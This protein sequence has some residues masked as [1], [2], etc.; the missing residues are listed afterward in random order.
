VAFVVDEYGEILGSITVDDI[1]EEI[2]GEFTIGI[3][4][5]EKMIHVQSD[6]SYLVDGMVPV[7]DFNRLVHWDLPVKGPRT[8]NGLITEHL[9]ALPR[10]GTGLLIAKYPIEIIEVKANR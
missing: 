3:T 1:L 6:G 7:R 5:L 4:D 8:F 2:V 9:Q 10:V